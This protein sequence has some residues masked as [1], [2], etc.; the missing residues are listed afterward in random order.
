ML[1]ANAPNYS[2]GE[3]QRLADWLCPLNFPQRQ[4][5]V[6]EMRREGTGEWIL[7]DDTFRRWH[8]GDLK[9]LW[10][11]GI[12]GAG[13]TIL[14]SYIIKHILVKKHK[15]N[16]VAVVYIYCNYKD[17]STQTVYNLVASLLKQLVQD[18]PPTFER[19]KTEYK[20]H[21]ERHVRPTLSEVRNTLR[22]EITE[23]SQVFVVADALDEVS[24]DNRR[25]ELLHSLQSLGGSLL[26]TS[27]D[28]PTIG[29]ALYNNER[30]DIRAR[31]DDMCKYIDGRIR[32]GSHLTQLNRL[33]DKHP[34][35][36]QKI[37]KY[38][39]KKAQGMFLLCR[40]HLD[41][42]AC[43]LTARGVLDALDRLPQGIN[44]AYDD[45]MKRIN[46]LDEERRLLAL[47]TI[48]LIASALRPL[49]TRELQE[50]VAF[51]S[52]HPYIKDDDLVDETFIMDI[53]AG[54]VMATKP[55]HSIA[56]SFLFV[57]EYLAS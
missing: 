56:R 17:Q 50:A 43:K 41:S 46:T 19:V 39:P 13:K 9:T 3:R 1:Y 57:R 54:L 30:M 37:I 25:A 6:N 5:E 35:V 34:H 14:A 21:L 26:V 2:D 40:L 16:N 4:S 33:L 27:R 53:C 22:K 44:D 12:P 47:K 49:T 52:D 36:K 23:F 38:L 20:S 55:A 18:F 45:T 8:K 24:E 48:M 11:P 7:N 42:L 29:A 32:S 31:E 10:C 15:C 28:I 51:S